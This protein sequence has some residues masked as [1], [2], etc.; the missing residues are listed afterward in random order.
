MAF[1]S[2]LNEMWGKQVLPLGKPFRS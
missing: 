1:A 2:L